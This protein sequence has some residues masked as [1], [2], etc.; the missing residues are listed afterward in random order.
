MKSSAAVDDLSFRERLTALPADGGNRA[1]NP[2]GPGDG[3]CRPPPSP[4]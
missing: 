3:Q 2:D 1:E 4:A